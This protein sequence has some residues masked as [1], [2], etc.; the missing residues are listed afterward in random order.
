MEMSAGKV[1]W[2]D[3]KSGRGSNTLGFELP[4]LRHIMKGSENASI[5]KNKRIGS[6]AVCSRIF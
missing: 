6:T 4:R 2:P 1:V 3:W 5:N